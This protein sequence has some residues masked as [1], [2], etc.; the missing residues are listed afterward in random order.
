MKQLQAFTSKHAVWHRA[1]ALLL[2]LTM[3]FS[4]CV[5]CA[6]TDEDD[7]DEG[8]I[9]YTSL[10]PKEHLVALESAWLANL[11]PNTNAGGGLASMGIDLSADVRLGDGLKGMFASGSPG[12]VIL[13]QVSSIA[14]DYLMI[15]DGTKYQ[16]GLGAGVNGVEL[17]AVEMIIDMANYAAWVSLPGLSDEDV[18]IDISAIMESQGAGA[19]GIVMPTMPNLSNLSIDPEL[20]IG[21]IKDYYTLALSGIKNVE[22]KE[23]SLKCN[24]VEQSAIELT[25]TISEEEVAKIALDVLKK[26][27]DD[28]RIDTFVDSLADM[29]GGTLQDVG[30]VDLGDLKGQLQD[31]IEEGIDYFENA[32]FTDGNYITWKVYTDKKNNVIGREVAVYSQNTKMGEVKFAS[33]SDGNDYAL[34]LSFE[35]E[36]TK[37]ALSGDGS[38]KNGKRDGEFAVSM[39]SAGQT[40]KFVTFELEDVTSTGGKLKI[41]PTA[42][43]LNMILGGGAGYLD[44]ALEI[45][46]DSE[47]TSFDVLMN[48]MLLIGLDVKSEIKDNVSVKTPEGIPELDTLEEMEAWASGIDI[49]K[50][51]ERLED[52]GLADLLNMILGGSIG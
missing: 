3:V 52:A 38:E 14:I 27:K 36:Q 9:D 48:D 23:T 24:G 29:I 33:V 25:A 22:R 31:V 39:T 8:S 50:L 12:A 44:L 15:M 28:S 2:A 13:D 35:M 43:L 18:K 34:N 47:K 32:T 45:K 30:N 41:E 26:A 46:W 10:S 19:A 1:L 17:A 40:V 42:D 21:L 37:F 49:G 5:G 51:M 6:S 20:V 4:L 16:L 7:D 11:A